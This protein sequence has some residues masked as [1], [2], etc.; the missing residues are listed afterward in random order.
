MS[1][2]S[3]PPLPLLK[4]KPNSEKIKASYIVRTLYG[5]TGK[6]EDETDAINYI[7]RMGLENFDFDYPYGS[8]EEFKKQNA[9]GTFKA[10]EMPQLTKEQRAK[11]EKKKRAGLIWTRY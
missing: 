7:E 11:F 1:T 10:P 8:F 9:A 3:M 5:E 2:M 6:I 4:H